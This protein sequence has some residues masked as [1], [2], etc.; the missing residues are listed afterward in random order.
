M[1][2]IKKIQ[3]K[4]YIIVKKS[5]KDKIK[6]YSQQMNLYQLKKKNLVKNSIVN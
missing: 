5:Q 2:I 3:K 4:K 1:K 6:N